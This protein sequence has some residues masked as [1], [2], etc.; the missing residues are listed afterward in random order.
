MTPTGPGS[1]P[2]RARR[3][4]VHAL[5]EPL[6][7]RPAGRARRRRDPAAAAAGR[8]AAH[9]ADAEERGRLVERFAA[10]ELCAR[11]A[12]RD[13]RRA[14]GALRVPARAGCLSRARRRARARARR[15]RWSSTTRATGS[16]ARIRRRSSTAIRDPA[17]RLRAR[18]AARRSGRGR[19]RARV[20]GGA[21]GAG[22]RDVRARGCAGARDRA[23]AAGRGGACG[24]QFAVTERRTA[25]SVRAARPR[26][27][28]LLAGGDDA[29][30]GARPAV[31]SRPSGGAVDGRLA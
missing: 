10:S 27:A 1:P 6:D 19:G 29:A 25:T 13:P 17:P 3:S 30:R 28:L 5:L 8:L 16:T 18:G 7:F 22:H 11:L 12:P 2:R 21:R 20:P 9:R 24:E 14:R 26:A 15:R 4:L 23:A 31:L